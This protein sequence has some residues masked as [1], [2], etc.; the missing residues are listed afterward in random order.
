MSERPWWAPV[1]QW[2]LW[3]V[4]MALV[5]GYLARRRSAPRPPEDAGKLAHPVSTLIIGLG[6]GGFFLAIA[7]LCF[8]FPGKTGAPALSLFFVGFALLGLP[9]VLDYRNARHML[10]ADGMQFGRMLGG[11][12]VLKW[13]A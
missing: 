10:L 8:L 9:L 4:I 1:L 6:C 7:L 5:M 13:D 3:A 12:G 11:R 2:G